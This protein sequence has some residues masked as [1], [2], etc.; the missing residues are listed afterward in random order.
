MCASLGTRKVI[1]ATNIAESSIT[2][3]DVAH[4]IDFGLIKE[5]Y[6]DSRTSLVHDLPPPKKR[7][8]PACGLRLSDAL[9]GLG[10][11]ESLQLQ[12]TS[13]ASAKQRMGR[14]GR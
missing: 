6:Y 5:L 11:Q 10:V 1:L 9:L 14:A 8:L 13:K 7:D 3:P 2:V 4:V 12:W